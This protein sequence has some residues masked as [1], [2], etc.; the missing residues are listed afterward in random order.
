MNIAHVET[1]LKVAKLKSFSAAAESLGVS[2]GLVSRHIKA[3]EL[4][5][6]C[7]LLHRT[8]R[9][10]SLT[11]A[12]HELFE[13]AQQIETLMLRVS[14]N[15][16]E[17][18]QEDRGH[19]RFTA[20][21]SLGDKLCIDMIA[22]YRS[23]YPNVKIELDFST[24]IKDVEFGDFDVALR[25]NN[26]LPDNLISKD[27]GLMKNV[28]VASPD[29]LNDQSIV[30]PADLINI[31]CI[32]N[33]FNSNWNQLILYSNEW[34]KVVIPTQGKISCSNYE[35]IVTLAVAGD[36]LASL[37]FPIVEDLLH[38]GQLV[39]VLP[40]WHSSPHHFYLLYAKQRFYPKKLRDFIDAVV[41]WR[42]KNS[43]FFV[44]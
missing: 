14:K 34:Q 43:R 15:I 22:G 24:D 39:R 40:M 38:G 31:E 28:L 16:K 44:S 37:P 25:T 1:F 19:I 6:E 23:R 41:L 8:T 21:T 35:V 4:Q 9:N 12:G 13:T 36:G 3:L 26:H 29:W 5:L 7:S 32:Q 20:P 10:V 17:L 11:E 33:S 42:D 18:Q 27:F 2:K 30:T